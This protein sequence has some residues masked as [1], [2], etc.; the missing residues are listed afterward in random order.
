LLL[1]YINTQV[2]ADY[3]RG[4]YFAN[5]GMYRP[6]KGKHTPKDI[7]AGLCTHIFYAFVAMNPD[8]TLKVSDSWADLEID[9]VGQYKQVTDLK[10]AQ[11]NLKVL[12]SFGGWT[13]SQNFASALQTM[14]SSKQNRQT[15][16]QSVVQFLKKYNFDGFDV[17]WEY[18]NQQT[19]AS[20]TLLIQDLRSAFDSASPRLLLTAAVPAGISSIDAGFDVPA[21][22]NAFD[23][24]N[25]MSYD[26][27]ENGKTSFNSPL[28][29]RN[30]NKLSVK[31]AAE[32]WASK[33]F[34]KNKIII[35]LADYGRGYT[36]SNP[37]NTAVGAPAGSVSPAQTY[38]QEAGIAFYYEICDMINS[39]GK[40][41]WD[42]TQQVPYLV[43]GNI[44]M[45]YD[46][47]D[48]FTKK[49]QYVKQNGFGG[50]FVWALHY[51]DFNGKSCQGGQKYP[52]TWKMNEI[53]GGGSP[54]PTT[55]PDPVVVTPKPVGTVAP[56]KPTGPFKCNSAG[57]FA[58]PQS[59]TNY[60]VCDS[61]NYAN[62]MTC[63]PGLNFN[64]QTKNCDWPEAAKCASG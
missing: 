29:E 55:K 41:F 10:K 35:G 28:Y 56:S 19:K 46:N 6:D 26:L 53:L 34:P 9:G 21:L 58:D 5:W 39:G 14:A 8:Y 52:L 37:S 1:V 25:I 62:R 17:D 4:C 64:A 45:G 23:L 30:G 22:A 15:F 16:V 59:C 13:F 7:P 47:P 50:A 60:Y 40:T 3:V 51:D 12:L 54:P 49:L 32:Y 2:V 44:W 36:L 38:S 48:S 63:P 18:P 61:S 57:I 24:L 27:Q 42:D 20:Y 31:T 33:G 43:K 11:P